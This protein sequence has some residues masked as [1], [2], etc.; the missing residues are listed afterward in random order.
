MCALA[1]CKAHLDAQGRLALV[2]CPILEPARRHIVWPVR[3]G[4][5]GVCLVCGC[6]AHG[7]CTDDGMPAAASLSSEASWAGTRYGH[8]TKDTLQVQ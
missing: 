8:Q 5:R 2:H 3:R 4:I 7:G 6:T 1:A